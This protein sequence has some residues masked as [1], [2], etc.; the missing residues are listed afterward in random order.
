MRAAFMNTK[1]KYSV[2]CFL[3]VLQFPNVC[4][5]REL[6]YTLNFNGFR[7][8]KN[9]VTDALSSFFG[10]ETE[11]RSNQVMIRSDQ[12]ETSIQQ[13]Y[14]LA[15]DVLDL[16]LI[17]R[18]GIDFKQEISRTVMFNVSL[19]HGR[20]SGK[21]GF[22]DGLGIFSDPAIMHSNFSENLLFLS[23]EKQIFL[24]EKTYIFGKVGRNF[25]AV[26]IDTHIT[27]ALL[28][29]R[30]SK[31]HHISYPE[32]TLGVRFLDGLSISPSVSFE[33]LKDPRN[34]FSVSLSISQSF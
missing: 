13:T 31:T 9:A 11:D 18:L 12:F 1:L 34:S 30:S 26:D 27:S 19:S 14:S 22:P 20:G 2:I 23:L 8:D 28:D 29:V 16:T 21:Y 4:K 32:Y 3:L 7:Y 10:V 6:S 25:A 33:N 5:A 17:N 24:S 15:F